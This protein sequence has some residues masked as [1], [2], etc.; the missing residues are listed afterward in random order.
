[1]GFDEISFL[2]ADLTTPAFNRPEPW[3]EDRTSEV[4]IEG[5][6]LDRLDESISRALTL[7]SD[8]FENGFVAGGADAIDRIRHYYRALSDRG[9]LPA[10]QC[11]APW[12]SAVLEPGGAVRPCFF[13][14]AYGSASGGFDRILNAPAAIE[15]RQR[16]DVAGNPTCR[17]CVC[18]LNLPVT[19][20]V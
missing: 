18:S 9:I 8:L 6:D 14:E 19:R 7:S 3:S 1:M 4:V 2:A 20:T 11:N 5:D 12:V 15:F 13:H 16:L 10:V 17:R